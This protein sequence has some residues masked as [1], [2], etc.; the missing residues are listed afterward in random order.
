M[1]DQRT[2]LFALLIF[3]FSNLVGQITIGEARQM[4]EG[5]SVEIQGIVTH[6]DELGPIRYIQDATGAIPVYSP[7]AF[8][9]GTK[10]GDEVKVAGELKD[11]RGLLEIDPISSFSVISSDNN[12]PDFQEITPGQ[13]NEDLEGEL[14]K[15]NGVTF[16]DAGGVFSVGTYFFNGNGERGQSY[17]RSNHPLIGTNIPLASVNISGIVSQFETNYQIL[18]RGERDIEIADAFFFEENPAQSDI[19]NNGFS[20]NWKTNAEGTTTIKY[21][22]TTDLENEMSVSGNTADHSIQLTGLD[23]ATFYYVQAE[24]EK[25]GT[26]IKSS[27]KYF[28]TASNSS[29]EIKVYF[30]KS[31]DPTYSNGALS[32]STTPVALE[33]AIVEAI[34]NAKVS[35]DASLYNNNRVRIIQ[36]LQA[37]KDRGVQVRYIANNGSFNAALQSPHDFPVLRLN[38]DALMHN[39]YFVIDADSEMDSWVIAGSTNMTDVNILDDYNNMVFIQDQALAKSYRLEFEE[40]W[41]TSDAQPSVFTV[42]AGSSKTDNTPHYFLINDQLVENYFSPSDNTTLAI[43]NVIN[44][45]AESVDFAL[46][47]FT[48]NDLGTAILNAS[49]AGKDVRGIVENT[50]DQGTEFQFLKDRDVNITDHP[51]PGT[52]HHKY[53]IIDGKDSDGDPIVVTGSHNWSA[54]AEVRNDENTLI[55]HSPDVANIFVQEFEQRWCEI[56]GGNCFSNIFENDKYK[57][58]SVSVFPNPIQEEGIINIETNENLKNVNISIF[59][60]SGQILFSKIVPFQSQIPFS[61]KGFPAGTYFAQVQSTDYQGI[62]KI[63]KE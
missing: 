12:L 60:L 46:L 3:S 61:L 20:L 53:A 11:F 26:T 25:D 10:E 21:G 6:G 4:P 13:M 52:I 29:G 33:N 18:F 22:T 34:N 31:V 16:E 42:K 39:K 63:I 51:A 54:S 45:A 14:I 41:G 1:R 36:T 47:T 49:N 30:N 19:T 27:V 23:P 57:E 35:V 37:D 58:L 8:S 40:M 44:N 48:I 38:P 43:A 15:I 50:T 9:D 17:V 59:N 28:S 5:S 62:L 2:L 32:E 56:M 7:G 55:I 24:S